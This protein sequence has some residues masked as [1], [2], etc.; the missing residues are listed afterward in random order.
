MN[1]LTFV[2]AFGEPC[3][4]LGDTVYKNEISRLL[5]AYENTGL[6]PEEINRMVEQLEDRFIQYVRNNYGISSE[7]IIELLSNCNT[8]KFVQYLPGDIVYDKYGT[9]WTVETSEIHRFNGGPLLYLYRCGHPGTDNCC[10]LY[11][12]EIIT[13]EEA[14]KLLQKNGRF[15]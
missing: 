4:K 9:R 14:E 1:R 13:Q 2:D 15:T 6:T 5:A 12:H 3:Y 7:N 10:V 11:A 8:G